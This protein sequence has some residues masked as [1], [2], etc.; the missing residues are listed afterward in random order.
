M[1]GVRYVITIIEIAGPR[2]VREEQTDVLASHIGKALNSLEDV[3]VGRP[4]KVA[5][6]RV[7]RCFRCLE[8]GHTVANCPCSKTCADRCYRWG[9][10]GHVAKKCGQSVPN[11]PLCA[12]IRRRSDH[13]LGSK[14]CAPQD[15]RSMRREAKYYG[16]PSSKRAAP[17][18]SN[19]P[20]SMGEKA[21]NSLGKSR[22][23]ARPP[24]KKVRGATR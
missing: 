14:N 24:R 21:S 13:V 4:L 7:P 16:P 11:C 18:R 5:E 15:N 9:E 23:G 22:E 8:L 17:Q 3:K 1:H 6:V 20:S 10:Q 19:P 12:D 2:P